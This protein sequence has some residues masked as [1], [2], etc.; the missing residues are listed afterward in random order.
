MRE[1][2]TVQRSIFDQ[3]A[4]HE[5]GQ[6]LKAM[7]EWLEQHAEVLD[8]AAADISPQS[9]A[10]TGRPGLTVESIVRCALLKPYRQLSY[11]ELAF[12]LLDSASC[13]GLCAFVDGLVSAQVGVATGY[14]RHLR[15]HLGTVQSVF[16][17]V[18]PG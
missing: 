16:T 2:H 15:Q 5:I 9:V 12:C 14:Q 10:N 17:A 7:S 1:K 8:W 11:K 13:P 6:E 3:Y 18:R 4:E